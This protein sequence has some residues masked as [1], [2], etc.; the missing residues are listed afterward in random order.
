M[1]EDDYR[2]SDEGE[3]QPVH[4]EDDNGDEDGGVVEFIPGEWPYRLAA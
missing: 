3:F 4:D 1:I 2:W